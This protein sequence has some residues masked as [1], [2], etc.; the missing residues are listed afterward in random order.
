MS[1]WRQ[2]A[3]EVGVAYLC[4]WH[5]IIGLVILSLALSFLDW[6]LTFDGCENLAYKNKHNVM[7]SNHSVFRV[8]HLI[9]KI[10]YFHID[11]DESGWN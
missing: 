5:P 10:P 3:S 6:P 1:C 2:R 4:Q 9:A 11:L 8:Y 7:H